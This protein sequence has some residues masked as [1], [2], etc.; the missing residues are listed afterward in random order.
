VQDVK[1]ILELDLDLDS[2][3]EFKAHEGV[4]SLSGGLVDV[5]EAVVRAGLEVLARVLEEVGFRV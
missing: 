4:D 1:G 5:D 2:S 3:R